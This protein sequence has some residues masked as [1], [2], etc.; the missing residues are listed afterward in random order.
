MVRNHKAHWA[1]IKP[2]HEP[3][4]WLR[5]NERANI[6][7]QSSVSLADALMIADRNKE[8]VI[9]YLRKIAQQV[10]QAKLE[11]TVP[12]K[13]EPIVN[14]NRHRRNDK[15]SCGCGQ[16]IKNCPGVNR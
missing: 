9:E 14:P 1:Y 10:Q 13:I 7:I 11:E 16:K 3:Y 12:V 8:D 4:T 15:C 6:V 2:M 5:R